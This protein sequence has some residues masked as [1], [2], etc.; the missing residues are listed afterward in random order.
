MALVSASAWSVRP[1][2]Q[3]NGCIRESLACVMVLLFDSAAHATGLIKCN[4]SL[5][6]LV[7]RSTDT[8]GLLT[9][10]VS[11]ML[12][13]LVRAQQEEPNVTYVID[14]HVE[15]IAWYN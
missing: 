15:S 14:S 7:E 12:M 1:N 5:A 6:Q 3:V 11:L 4:S 2:G 13:S 9:R 8:D 10:V